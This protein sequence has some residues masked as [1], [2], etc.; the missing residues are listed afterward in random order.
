MIKT[1]INLTPHVSAAMLRLLL[2]HP[3]LEIKWVSGPGLPPEGVQGVFDELQGEI[4]P[5]PCDG[6]LADINLYIGNDFVGLDQY[7]DS[8]PDAKAILL[9]PLLR[10]EG[11][12]RGITGVCEYNRK[13]LVRGGQLAIQP[14][15]PTLLGALA[16]MPLAKNL[17]L[18]APVTGTMLL[19]ADTALGGGAFRVP[20]ATLP[21]SAF[22]TLR[23]DI[24]CRLQTSFNSPLEVTAIES[25][26]GSFACAVLTVDCKLD[27]AHVQQMY[28]D[29]YADHR[30]MVFA[31]H[32]V[33]EDMVRGTNKTV[34][35][36]GRDGLGRLLVTV[37]FDA[38]YKGSAGNVV[39]LLNLLFGLDERTGF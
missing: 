17:L 10:V 32:A 14:D 13:A 24:L 31:T 29:F 35:R 16:L 8:R 30:H 19:P 37:A 5:I 18:T 38:A 11:Y 27:Q 9:G 33:N 34:L 21:Q 39:H 36:L 6:S 3:D 7:L 12:E 26:A 28:T 4:G 23:D 15:V 1:G 2:Q 25:H 20:A 22:K